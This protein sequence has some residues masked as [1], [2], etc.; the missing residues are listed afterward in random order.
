MSFGDG[1]ASGYDGASPTF[2]AADG[3]DVLVAALDAGNATFHRATSEL[4]SKGRLETRGRDKTQAACVGRRV[5]RYD[6]TQ[7]Q[8][9][10]QQRPLV[11]EREEVYNHRH[12]VSVMKTFDQ[13]K[14]RH[15]LELLCQ[16][17]NGTLYLQYDERTIPR[18]TV[19]Y[20]D[21]R[22]PPRLGRRLAELTHA[23]NSWLVKYGLGGL[24]SVDQ[25]LEV[26]Q[27]FLVWPFHRYFK[28]IQFWD[29]PDE[30]PPPELP[31]L[32]VMREAVVAALDS[33]ANP[34]TVVHGAL[35]RSLLGPSSQTYFD[36]DV[37]QFVVVE[38]LADADE[39]DSWRS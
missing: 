24:V 3:F 35:R 33:D 19:L 32:P 5:P 15:R 6:G 10:R 39:L 16:S 26:Q 31:E 27:D 36:M 4:L 30:E 17:T 11:T 13:L 25:P 1:Y 7:D 21:G 18:Y 29:E 20:L 2:D 34:D 23:M 9:V 28:P 22:V 38:P 14:Q 37:E 8:A 12:A